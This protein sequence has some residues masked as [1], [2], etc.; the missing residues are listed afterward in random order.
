MD[1]LAISRL[2]TSLYATYAASPSPDRCGVATCWYTHWAVWASVAFS[3]ALATSIACFEIAGG[4]KS[5]AIRRSATLLAHAFIAIPT[6]RDAATAKADRR[7]QGEAGSTSN[8][9]AT[10]AST[11]GRNSGRTPRGVNRPSSCSMSSFI[12]AA[13]QTKFASSP[14]PSG[15]EWQPSLVEAQSLG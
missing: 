7:S 5:R 4:P 8:W 3:T 10:A 11:W 1:D 6:R 14:R 12:M 15:S 9:L 2:N 13:S